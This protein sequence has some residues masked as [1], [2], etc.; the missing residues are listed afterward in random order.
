MASN[1][2]IVSELKSYLDALDLER[3]EQIEGWKNAIKIIHDRDPVMVKEI[4]EE[5]QRTERRFEKLRK[6]TIKLARKEIELNEIEKALIEN[7]RNV[8]S[9]SG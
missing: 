6:K 9:S 8:S 3:K 7:L 4:E 1:E 5:I 2:E